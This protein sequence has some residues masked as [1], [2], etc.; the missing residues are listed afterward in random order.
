MS[1]SPSTTSMTVGTSC[2]AS[3]RERTTALQASR[4]IRKL[5]VYSFPHDCLLTS[6]STSCALAPGFHFMD[7]PNLM[8]SGI[9]ALGE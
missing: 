5:S 6:Y 4:L 9:L 3:R 8:F 2:K 1:T 7:E